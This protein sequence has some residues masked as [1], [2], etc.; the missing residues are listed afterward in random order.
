VT[1]KLHSSLKLTL[2]EF[3][4]DRLT[5]DQTIEQLRRKLG[6][7]EAPSAPKAPMNGHRPASYSEY[8][9]LADAA[10]ACLK[11][12]PLTKMRE[13]VIE[14]ELRAGGFKTGSSNLAAHI[15]T[16]L[17]RR[18]ESPLAPDE[19]IKLDDDGWWFEPAS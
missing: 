15:R 13:S 6:E 18:K 9:I 3:E 14:K 5:L 10:T 19:E 12:A 16:A 4:R 7:A 8:K 11:A 1:K 17:K 2:A